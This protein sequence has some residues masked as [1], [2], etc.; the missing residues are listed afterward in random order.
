MKRKTVRDHEPRTTSNL[1]GR[2]LQNRLV[3][4][5]P[6]EANPWRDM[7]RANR[8]IPDGLRFEDRPLDCNKEAGVCGPV[9]P[10]PLSVEEY[11]KLNRAWESRVAARTNRNTH[12]T[13]ADEIPP[14]PSSPKVEPKAQ[15]PKPPASM[16][17][18]VASVVWS[19]FALRG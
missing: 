1:F 2:A 17:Q 3:P 16:L 13:P 8:Q 19:T 14:A 12:T 4:R 6:R 7:Y 9:A 10:D 15:P 18:R 11:S 5:Q